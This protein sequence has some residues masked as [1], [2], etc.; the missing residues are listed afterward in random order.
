MKIDNRVVGEDLY[1]NVG[2]CW[3]MIYYFILFVIVFC[4]YMCR[5]CQESSSSCS[6]DVYFEVICWIILMI[7][8]VSNRILYYL[9]CCGFCVWIFV[10]SLWFLMLNFWLLID[11][12]D[13][14]YVFDVFLF[15]C[16]N[17]QK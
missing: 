8:E 12:V 1:W 6:Y 15:I 13:F 17:Y 14:R 11:V 5:V 9:F 7:W 2:R 10:F 16:F 3:Q 4:V